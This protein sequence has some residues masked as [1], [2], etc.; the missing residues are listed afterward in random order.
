MKVPMNTVVLIP[1]RLNSSRLKKKMLADLEGAPLIVRTWQQARK[2]SGVSRVV[3]ATDSEEIAG[4]MNSCG[5]EVVMTSSAARCGTDRIAEASAGIDAD[6]FINLQGDEPLIDPT[7]VELLMRPFREPGPPDCATLVYQVLSED[8]AVLE[9]P[10]TVKVVMD[11]NGDALYFSRSPLPYQRQTNASTRC[12]RHIGIYAFTASALRSFA[13]LGPSML[14]EAES[15]EQLRLIEHG[16]RIR[17]VET[18]VDMPGVN[19]HEDLELV[20]QLYRSRS[21]AR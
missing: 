21:A 14:E 2:A 20:R 10:N 5:A 6:L 1:A 19:T 11:R 3:I 16:M 4:V 18:A 12:Y 15:L 9:D 17:C 13:S 7:N 8:Y